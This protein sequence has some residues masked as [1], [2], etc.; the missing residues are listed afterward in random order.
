V[1]D[2]SSADVD[3]GSVEGV[4]GNKGSPQ[5]VVSVMNNGTNDKVTT[6]DKIQI[7]HAKFM[8]G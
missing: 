1:R 3:V 7:A 6:Q 2:R 5:D 4:V 8:R